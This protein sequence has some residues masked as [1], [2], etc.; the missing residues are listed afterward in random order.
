MV[1]NSV[2]NHLQLQEF[3]VIHNIVWNNET[4]SLI[5]KIHLFQELHGLV[6]TC[7]QLWVG[8]PV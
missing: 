8:T 3:N 6:H 2:S 4:Y 7:E 5:A 1:D